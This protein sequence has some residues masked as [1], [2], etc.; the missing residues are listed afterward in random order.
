[1]LFDGRSMVRNNAVLA[2][3]AKGVALPRLVPLLR[4]SDGRVALAVVDA[5]AH[6]SARISEL[7]PE[8]VE[9]L[10]GARA[11]V[12][13]AVLA[14]LL[15][16]MASAGDQLIAAMD[17][18]QDLAQKT[19]VQVCRMAGEPGIEL[20]MRAIADERS[21]V[22]INAMEGLASLEDPRTFR[23][24]ELLERVSESDPVADVRTTARSVIRRITKVWRN[25]QT[26][27]EITVDIEDFY[28]SRLTLE[29]LR[30]KQARIDV[31]TVVTA[32]EDGR[33]M[34]RINAARALA[35][36]GEDAAH[37]ARPLSM[38]LR[39]SISEVRLEAAR[40]LGALGS[41]TLETADAL[42]AALGDGEPTVAA[43]AQDSLRPLGSEALDPLFD[44]LATGSREHGRRILELMVPMD[45][46]PD[47]L[48]DAFEN[49]AVNVQVN[50][51]L[52]LGM[53]GPERVG[54]GRQLLEGARTGGFAE[55][56]AAV[57]EALAMLDAA[58]DRG[59]QTITVPDYDSKYLSEEALAA[60]KAGLDLDSLMAGLSDGREIVRANAAVAIAVLGVSDDRIARSLAPLLR[61]DIAQVRMAA[62]RSVAKLDG[63]AFVVTDDLVR[64]LGDREDA[65]A[66]VVHGVLEPLG[67]EVV[68]A[69][70][71]GLKTD[72]R[73]HA[74]RV[75]ALI[76]KLPDAADILCDAF[77]NPAVN[78]QV[79]A[80]IGL[81]MLGAKRIGYGK[82]LLE[83]ARTGGFA[84]TRAAVREALA[85]LEG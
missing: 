40:A 19:V 56:R 71:R 78:V 18:P 33:T 69:L 43:A 60:H 61:D 67:S 47:A 17:V 8:I 6:Q 41:G 30:A 32:L 48:C 2:L 14:V 35:A 27:Q 36:K 81:G 68:D 70:M 31:D 79:N 62:A 57:R 84:E 3:A 1:M 52:G 58:L 5:L 42:I 85:I 38:L 82:Q 74:L 44:G 49:P 45:A 9:T 25:S 13:E 63:A 46:A 12:I 4:D 77:E 37:A 26:T 51:A 11:E 53:L 50:A 22:R 72:E 54:Y 24:L 59:P 16:L 55:T 29:A 66:D 21:R 75:I 34:V 23:A 73:R 80:A 83:G 20:L 39:D 7:V 10:A 15:D 64:A 65:V 28:S 76:H